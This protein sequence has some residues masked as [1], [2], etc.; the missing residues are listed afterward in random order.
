M[1]RTLSWA[2]N[3]EM[4]GVAAEHRTGARGRCSA[5]PSFRVVKDAREVEVSDAGAASELYLKAAGSAGR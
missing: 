1:L 5:S 3:T 4:P 2:L